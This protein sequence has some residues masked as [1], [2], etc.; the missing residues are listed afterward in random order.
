MHAWKDSSSVLNFRSVVLFQVLGYITLY[1]I[2]VIKIMSKNIY[3]RFVLFCWI[4]A[5]KLILEEKRIG[6]LLRFFFLFFLD[7]KLLMLL[8]DI[9]APLLNNWDLIIQSVINNG[10]ISVCNSGRIR[11]TNKGEHHSSCTLCNC[12][13]EIHKRSL[14]WSL[15]LFVKYSM[16]CF[17]NWGQMYISS[18]IWPC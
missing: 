12:I 2:V 14:G 16:S 7:T 18:R 17:R 15:V 6:T 5:L 11:R 3:W 4:T 10:I 9:L 13:C 1:P 8:P